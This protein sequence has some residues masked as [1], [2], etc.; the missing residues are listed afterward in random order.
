[1]DR[2]EYLERRKEK[3][4]SGGVS[5]KLDDSR[6]FVHD[7]S[8]PCAGWNTDWQEQATPLAHCSPPPDSSVTQ[9]LLN[10][11]KCYTEVIGPASPPICQYCADCPTSFVDNHLW[12]R[13]KDLLVTPF[14]GKHNFIAYFYYFGKRRLMTSRFCLFVYVSPTNSFCFYAVHVVWKKSRRLV[15]P[16]LVY[17]FL[18][19]FFFLLLRK[20]KWELL[21][22]V[23]VYD[24][25]SRKLSPI[26][27]R[28]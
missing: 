1:M 11:G 2:K 14:I 18:P 10:S 12:K 22:L 26:T 20:V 3:E 23:S 17:I 15:L 5:A 7:V 21:W 9:G 24:K 28:W 8:E 13:G 27:N 6:C 19:I 4:E 16:K 25:K